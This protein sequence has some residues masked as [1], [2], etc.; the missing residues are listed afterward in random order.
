MLSAAEKISEGQRLK[1]EATA[2]LKAETDSKR[3]T[4][5]FKRCFA[6][7]RGLLPQWSELVP[8]ALAVGR[9]DTLIDEDQE[10]SVRALELACNQGLAT[11]Y[12]RNGEHETALRYSEKVG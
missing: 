7:T 6:Y 12:L 9:H 2:L 11:I 1:N 10:A 4:V 8:Y 3:A 5:L